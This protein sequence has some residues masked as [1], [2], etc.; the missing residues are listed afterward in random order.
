MV[1][2]ADYGENVGVLTVQT[3]L[4]VS[5]EDTKPLLGPRLFIDNAGWGRPWS[6]LRSSEPI[7]MWRL[8]K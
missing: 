8:T 1:G 5:G 2:S 4:A 3:D 6:I 7:T